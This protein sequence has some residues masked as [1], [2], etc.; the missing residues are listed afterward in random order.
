MKK[1]WVREGEMFDT[2]FAPGCGGTPVYLASEVEPV[3]A[4]TKQFAALLLEGK[5]LSEEGLMHLKAKDD[6]I[7]RLNYELEKADGQISY[8]K[9][10]L[11]EATK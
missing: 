3:L 9:Q 1:H 8:L 6:E 10:K 7:V 5:A 2:P 11:A 4:V